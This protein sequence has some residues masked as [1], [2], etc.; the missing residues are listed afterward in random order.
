MVG[1]LK[2]THNFT[3]LE[4]FDKAFVNKSE[5]ILGKSLARNGSYTE[6]SEIPGLEAQMDEEKLKKYVV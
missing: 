2:V 1:E 6:L 4:H 3:I 5:M